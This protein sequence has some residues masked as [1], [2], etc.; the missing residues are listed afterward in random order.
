M[1]TDSLAQPTPPTRR[2][3]RAVSKRRWIQIRLAVLLFN[4]VSLL[5]IVFSAT[6]LLGRIQDSIV[7]ERYSRPFFEMALPPQTV[8]LDREAEIIREG[9]RGCRFEVTRTVE[10]ALSQEALAAHLHAVRFQTPH[11]DRSI[12][13][14]DGLAVVQV[15]SGDAANVYTLTLISENTYQSEPPWMIGC[16]LHGVH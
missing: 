7:M 3:L 8:E 5:M 16:G 11:G 12:V 15:T 14:D 10:S 1:T 6:V 9:T 4:P 2:G 13:S